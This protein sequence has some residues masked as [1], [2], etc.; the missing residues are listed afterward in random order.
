MQAGSGP[1][2][3]DPSANSLWLKNSILSSP[4]F[5][6]RPSRRRQHLD[7]EVRIRNTHGKCK[8]IEHSAALNPN[9]ISS[10]SPGLD[11]FWGLPRVAKLWA[12]STP[13]EFFTVARRA[14]RKMPAV[15]SDR[16]RNNATAKRTIRKYSLSHSLISNV[17]VTCSPFAPFILRPP[18]EPVRTGHFVKQSQLAAHS[19]ATTYKTRRLKMTCSLF[20]NYFENPFFTPK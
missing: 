17:K 4:V 5:D 14:R 8:A 2:V 7:Y 20:I 11:R 6:P 12:Y 15:A 13:T 10:Q 1:S 9:G 19:P 18:G 16:P 3:R